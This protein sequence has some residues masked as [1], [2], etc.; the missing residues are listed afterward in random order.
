VIELVAVRMA[1]LGLAT[2]MARRSH[3]SSSGKEWVVAH[4]LYKKH[5]SNIRYKKEKNMR[6]SHRT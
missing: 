6:W 3:Q 2:K 4:T 1:D 5:E